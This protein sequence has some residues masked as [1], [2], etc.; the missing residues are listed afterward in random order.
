MQTEG[1]EGSVGGKLKKPSKPSEGFAHASFIPIGILLSGNRGL[2]LVISPTFQNP[3]CSAMGPGIHHAS[4]TDYN[5]FPLFLSQ[6]VMAV[7]WSFQNRE[8]FAPPQRL[9]SIFIVKVTNE[10]QSSLR[11][12]SLAAPYW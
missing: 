10:E 8:V 2:H 3:I 7:S 5:F 6:E 4:C 11:G 9:L 12:S 1:E